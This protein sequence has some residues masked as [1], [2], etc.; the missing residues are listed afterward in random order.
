MRFDELDEQIIALLTEDA[1][2]S[3]REVARIVGVSEAAI[4]KRLKRL[5]V[6]KAAKVAAV[7]NPAAVGLEL[8]AFVRLQTSPGVARK[9]AEEAAKLNFVSFVAL[10]TGRFNVVTLVTTTNR[11]TLADL[12]HDNFRCWPGVHHIDTVELVSVTKHRLD[13]VRITGQT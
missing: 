5:A 3:N 7:V 2:T 8:A 11:Q 9:V 12:V 1:R 4:R 6:Q 13:L 10:T